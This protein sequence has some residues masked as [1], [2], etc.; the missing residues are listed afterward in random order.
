MVRSA[1]HCTATEVQPPK[2]TASAAPAA[3][4]A[5]LS[6]LDIRVGKVVEIG[7]HPEADGIFVQQVDVGDAAGPRTIASKLVEFCKEEDLLNSHVIVLCNL[8][9]RVL[10]GI[11][12]SG[13]LLCASNAEHTQVSG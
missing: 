12:S 4:L 1:L 3:K 5:D 8:K 9:P 2:A 10:K 13:M 6:L 7:R 11:T